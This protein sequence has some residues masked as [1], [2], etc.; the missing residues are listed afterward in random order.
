MEE[1]S[2]NKNILPEKQLPNAQR[3]REGG[4]GRW[5]RERERVG[6]IKETRISKHHLGFHSIRQLPPG[7]GRSAP[8]PPS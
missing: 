5:R 2:D 1:S 7:A 4:G 6:E 8:T 3:Y